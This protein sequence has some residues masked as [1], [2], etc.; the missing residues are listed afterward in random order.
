MNDEYKATLAK[1][2]GQLRSGYLLTA[3]M[4]ELSNYLNQPLLPK[5]LV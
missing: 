4:V 5:W 2:F 1:V 3:N